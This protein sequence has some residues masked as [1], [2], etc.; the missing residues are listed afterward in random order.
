VRCPWYNFYTLK[1]GLPHPWLLY[2]IPWMDSTL[3][4][5]DSQY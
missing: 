5:T 4:G 3:A 1:P 2:P